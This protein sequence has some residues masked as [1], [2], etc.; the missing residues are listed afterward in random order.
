MLLVSPPKPTGC[1][2]APG[3][4]LIPVASLKADETSQDPV[5]FGSLLMM[6]RFGTQL[7]K[8]AYINADRFLGI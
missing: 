5:R 2:L 1:H 4:G 3:V 7:H 8:Y 6:G